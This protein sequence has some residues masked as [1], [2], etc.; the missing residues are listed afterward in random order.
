MPRV[1]AKPLRAA[2]EDEDDEYDEERALKAKAPPPSNKKKS[3]APFHRRLITRRTRP[4]LSDC[5][6][7]QRCRMGASAFG[8]G[9]KWTLKHTRAWHS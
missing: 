6:G 4:V 2:V 5:P 8:E 1:K 3:G 9:V 7:A